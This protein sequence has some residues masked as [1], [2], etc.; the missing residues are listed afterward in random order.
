[1]TVAIY[2][3]VSTDKQSKE[4]PEQQ[5]SECRKKLT[6]L[7]IDHSD[8]EV[9]IDQGISGA[10]TDRPAYQRL[11]AAV[12]GGG[13]T[14]VALWAQS[15][16]GRD[17]DEVSRAMR[18]IESHGIRLLTCDGYDSGTMS[19]QSR[20]LMRGFK[21]M[22]DE[23]YLDDLAIAVHRGLSGK[24]DKLHWCGGRVYGY[25]LEPVYGTKLDAYKR[26][27]RDHTILAI[28]E[29]QAAIVREIFE[30]H[31]AGDSSGVIAADLTSRG[32]PSPGTFWKERT[33]RRAERWARSG[34]AAMLS[35]ELY[36]GT[37][38]WNTTNWERVDRERERDGKTVTVKIRICRPRPKSEWKGSPKNV[39][40]LE[41]INDELF[42]KVQAR[43]NANVGKPR[44]VRLTRG[45]GARYLVSGLLRCPRCK[46][47]FVLDSAT[48]YK[49]AAVK[50]GK[51][52][53]NPARV[54]RLVVEP[55]IITH[56]MDQLLDPEVVNSV[57]KEMQ[58]YFNE[59]T[60]A[61]ERREVEK[62]AALL[63]IEAEIARLRAE[64]IG[65]SAMKAKLTQAT[66]IQAEAMKAELMES[67]PAAKASAKILT[68]LPRA[69]E[70]YR[71]QLKKGLERA[72]PRDVD[73]ARAAVR[74]LAGGPIWI[75]QQPGEA[76][77]FA[78]FFADRLAV[79]KAAGANVVVDG[80]G[81]RI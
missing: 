3:R 69:A 19:K 78:T 22:M 27:E 79:A 32:V 62:P 56:L 13:I 6:S 68:V 36:N 17:A 11:L 55:L 63:E 58:R 30:R 41:I 47:N 80:S 40:Y 42:K 49:C 44:D 7:G 28:N 71:L 73:R 14:T 15:R 4:S 70:L 9:Y 72:S 20:K 75:D 50:D 35:N 1:M 81:G 43:L 57:A 10:R 34:I 31:A 66:L 25:D 33:E 23:A 26:P 53:D 5:V 29:E 24:A 54:S 2:A 74:Q 77:A 59:R 51:A 48:H 8:A 45:G 61:N 39:P 46:A 18:R 67:Q 76:T 16:L 12:D 52:C 37:Y 64:L 21:G 60:A 38:Y 65:A